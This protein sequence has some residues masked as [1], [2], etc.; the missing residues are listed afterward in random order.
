[1]LVDL[2]S[3]KVAVKNK[4]LFH[5]FDIFLFGWFFRSSEKKMYRFFKY[6]IKNN[7]EKE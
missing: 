2:I 3:K 7:L 4:Q 6:F 5:S 1:M